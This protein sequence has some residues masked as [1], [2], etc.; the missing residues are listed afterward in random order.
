MPRWRE[1]KA[2]EVSLQTEHVQTFWSAK[3]ISRVGWQKAAEAAKVGPKLG[4]CSAPSSAK[5][6][7]RGWYMLLA[8]WA[9]LVFNACWQFLACWV[10]REESKWMTFK[11]FPLESRNEQNKTVYHIS[12][13]N[14]E[15][16]PELCRII[17]RRLPSWTLAVTGWGVKTSGERTLP[18]E[19]G[20]TSNL[21]KRGSDL[22]C[23]WGQEVP[24]WV[25]GVSL[26][27]WKD[28]SYRSCPHPQKQERAN[29]LI[30][31]TSAYSKSMRCDHSAFRTYLQRENVSAGKAKTFCRS[32][33]ILVL[34]LLWALRVEVS[35]HGHCG[36]LTFL[37]LHGWGAD[38]WVQFI[39]QGKYYCVRTCLDGQLSFPGQ[40]S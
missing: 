10:S 6:D 15:A 36:E 40:Y 7:W 31:C 16:D 28:P 25:Q 37:R 9:Q 13:P 22:C 1:C 34:W 30:T 4:R 18:V 23:P 27:S 11:V 29:I 21:R 35:I 33:V 17:S 32:I 3:V 5:A 2:T 39:H 26:S 24:G 12:E 20:W 38:P 8:Y 14:Y 19:G